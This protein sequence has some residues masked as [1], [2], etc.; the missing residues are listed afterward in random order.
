MSDLNG[1]EPNLLIIGASTRAA[2]FSAKR[3][4]YRPLCLDIFAD[5]DL[6]ANAVVR[7][8][9]NYPQ[10]LIQA[11]Q[12]LPRFPLL[13]VGGLENQPE[14]L[15]VARE[16]HDLLG[17]D[18]DV[19]AAARDPA[20][21]AESVRMA[22]V[23]MPEWRTAEEPPEKDGT[24]ILRP[25]FGS[26]GRGIQVWNEEA[27]SS[28]VLQ[29]PHG[30]QKL[31]VGT[32]YS[33]AYIA[34]AEPGDIRFVG[35]TEQLIGS[36]TSGAEKFQWSG[37]IGPTTL[38]IPV[39]HKMRRVGNILKWKLG[40]KGLFGVDFLVTEDERIFVTEVNPRYPASLELLEFA[41]GQVLLN[42][43]I[44]CFVEVENSSAWS[45]SASG[46]LFGKAILYAANPFTM[47][48][49][50]SAEISDYNEFPAFADLPQVGTSFNAG[51]PVCTVFAQG[52]TIQQCR[53]SISSMLQQLRERLES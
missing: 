30:F 6:Q 42:D 24:W 17:N 45:P 8:I 36:K 53:E 51:E 49:D 52:A 12:S 44:Q 33:G 38:S 35:V 21:L 43:H 39:E 9:E 25:L 18:A 7:R 47:N 26:G 15:Q 13:Y 2:A 1:A 29:E 3:A 37:N 48:V 22:Q 4:G 5:A 16:R 32:P 23:E 10:G 41:T 34:S 28:D 46:P 20:Q 11:L 50:L 40:L 14:V 27:A 31:I 19:V